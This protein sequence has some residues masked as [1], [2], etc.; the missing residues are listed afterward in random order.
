MRAYSDL[1]G[2]LKDIQPQ[3]F[4][5]TG[6]QRS[7]TRFT[8]N[9]ISNDLGLE[10]VDE[11]DYYVDN[12][13]QFLSVVNDKESFVVQGPALSLWLKY[14]PDDITIIW[15]Y[16]DINDIIKSQERINWNYNY[17]YVMI[18]K[19][20][21]GD[22]LKD[23]DMDQPISKIKYDIWEQ[24]Q[25]PTLKNKTYNLIYESLSNHPMWI[26]KEQ[27]RYFNYKQIR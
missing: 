21:F 22:Q 24:I 8:A 11:E 1:L 6:P 26:D 27:R 9:V 3:K 15:M 20:V 7:G 14:V 17:Q 10:Y 23:I 12:M 19:Y 16:R 2:E 4:L 13:S 5:V 25:E 18:Y